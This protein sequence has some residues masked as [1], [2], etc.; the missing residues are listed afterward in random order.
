MGELTRPELQR[1]CRKRGL[2]AADHESWR[3]FL[4]RLLMST[5]AATYQARGVPV[6]RLGSVQRSAAVLRRFET[7]AA[8]SEAELETEY[9]KLGLQMSP[10]SGMAVD[11]DDRR[12]VLE[13][14]RSVAV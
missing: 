4:E 7:L 2:P 11:G 5:C 6:F 12:V 9:Y 1:E 8:M 13:P 10:S 3:D 14:L